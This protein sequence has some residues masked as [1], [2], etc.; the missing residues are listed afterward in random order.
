MNYQ[1]VKTWK[2]FISILVSERNQSEV[3]TY[4]MIPTIWHSG[5]CKT[6]D[7]V[8]R[9]VVARGCRERG[10][11]GRA[12][13]SLGAVKLFCMMLQCRIHVIVHLSKP[14]ECT[15]PRVNCNVNYGLWA[16]QVTWL[17][18][19]PTTRTGDPR[20][21]GSVP[22]SGRSPGE[23]NGN[24]LQYS[25]PENP[26]DKRSLAGYSSRGWKRVGHDLVTKTRNNNGVSIKHLERRNQISTDRVT[27]N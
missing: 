12:W 9:S 10:W 11:I 19:N 14:M 3:A 21:L 4:C 22:G 7:T 13:R 20:Y 25:R 26:M 24:P 1:T 2:N 15:T 8:K 5:K 16:S 17:V 23:G 18:K 6:M 27:D